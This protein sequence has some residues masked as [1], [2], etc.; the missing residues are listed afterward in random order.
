VNRV[1]THDPVAEL[2]DD[3]R[4]I[5]RILS[6]REA[7]AL[8]GAGSVALV[9]AACAP[10]ALSSAGGGASATAAAGSSSSVASSATAVAAAGSL[11]TCVVVPELTEGPYYVDEKLERSDIRIDTADGST[12]DGATLRIDWVVSQVD[13]TACIPLEGVLVDVW[14]CNAQGEY[15]DVSDQGFNTLGHNYLRGYQHT[16][17]NGNA[18]ITTIYPGWYR[19]RAVHVHFKIRTD[20][21]AT[22]GFDFT[23]QLF[24]DDSLSDRV[25]SQGPYASKGQRDVLNSND[26]IYQQTQG[27]TL[28]APKKDGDGYVATFEIAIQTT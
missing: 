11:P 22:S 5:G 7:L 2:D 25:F 10:S 28:L 18:T 16:D 4:P 21:T 8:M 26:G 1:P 24:F 14:H 3:D 15:S 19:G 6:R 17:A 23:S 27:L 20:P 9:A 13:G 12:V